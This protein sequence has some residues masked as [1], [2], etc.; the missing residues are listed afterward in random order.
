MGNTKEQKDGIS[1][2]HLVED[3]R[4]SP[5]SSGDKGWAEN[6]REREDLE[7]WETSQ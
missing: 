1:F 7:E 5:F 6:C 4:K 3:Y 2:L